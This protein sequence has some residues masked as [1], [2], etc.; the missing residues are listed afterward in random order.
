MLGLL[1]TATPAFGCDRVAPWSNLGQTATH[2]AEPLPLSL[3]AAGLVAPL[4]MAPTGADHALR[5]FNQVELGGEPNLEPVSVYAPYVFPFLLI[6][7]DAVA[8]P[9]GG[10]D[11]MRPT[12]AMIQ[13][14][15]LT[16]ATAT[17]LK[18]VTGRGWPNAGG[19]PK[20]RDRLEH[21]EYATRFYWFSWDKG[22][23]WPSGHTATMMGAAA[24][25]GSVT[26]H[27]V[28]WG[29]VGY[30]LTLGVASG[31]WLGDHHWASDIVSGGLLGFAIGQGVG[32]AFRPA[33]SGSQQQSFVLLPWYGS[34]F[35]GLRLAATF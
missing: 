34:G 19:D 9:L 6:G 4:A 11:V 35:S 5:R 30:A 17:T 18:W 25:L 26:E 20:A 8:A 27:R 15:V 14:F 2:F 28:W 33:T 13:G 10:C 16:L 1:A 24:A 21:P 7:L 22:Y 32:K 23:A 31:M 29:Y 12:S 3:T